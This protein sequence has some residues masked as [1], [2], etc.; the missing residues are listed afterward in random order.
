M[1]CEPNFRPNALFGDVFLAKFATVKKIELNAISM[2][3]HAKALNSKLLGYG[4]CY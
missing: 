3:I 4:F 1:P 2:I